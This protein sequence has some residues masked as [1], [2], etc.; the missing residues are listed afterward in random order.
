MANRYLYPRWEYPRPD[1]RRG[2]REGFDWINLN[3][4]WE[5]R[6]DGGRVGQEAGW[7][8]PEM[9]GWTSQ[10]IV[11]FCWESMAAWG[12]GEAAGSENYFSRRP[13]LNAL[14]ITRENYRSAPRYEV[15]WYRRKVSVPADGPWEGKRVIVTIGAADFFTDAWCNGRHLGHHE[16][17]YLP[18]EFDLTD[19]LEARDDGRREGWLVLRVEDPMDNREQPVGKQWRWYTSTSGIWQTVWIEPRAEAH[20]RQFRIET[21][22]D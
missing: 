6:F 11:P 16:G 1:R 15:G 21:D 5:F 14:D 20:I 13:Y 7:F 3:G 10:I 18:F 8:R 2:T 4:P 9:Q 19:A 17:G 12:D 22:I